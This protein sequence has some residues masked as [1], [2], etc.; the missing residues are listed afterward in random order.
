MPTGSNICPRAG[1]SACLAMPTRSASQ[2]TFS[3]RLAIGRSRS[4]MAASSTPSKIS[5]VPANSATVG[6]VISSA[7]GPKPPDVTIKSTP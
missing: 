7:V 2:S 3:Q 1:T 5:V 4:M 6:S